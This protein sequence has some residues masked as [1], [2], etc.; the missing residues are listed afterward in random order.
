MYARGI[1]P[2]DII[3]ERYLVERLIARGGMGYVVAATHIGFGDRVAIKILF[4]EAAAQQE[5][6]QRFLREGRVARKITSPHVV[7]VTD[8]GTLHSGTPYMIMEYLDGTDLSRVLQRRGPLPVEQAT[9]FVL[10]VCEALAEAHVLGIVHRDLK[11]A[12]LFLTTGADGSPIVKVLDF[13]IAK[14]T[15]GIDVVSLTNTHSVMG[16][17]PYMPPEQLE[18][19]RTVDPR[20]DIWS[21]GVVLFELVSGR[22]P[23]EGPSLP[24]VFAR[25]LQGQP[26]RLDEVMPNAPDG[27][28][29]TIAQCLKRDRDER[30]SSVAEFARAL[31]PF[32]SPAG[33]ASIATIQSVWRRRD[34]AIVFSSRDPSATCSATTVMAKRPSEQPAAPPPGGNGQ[35]TLAN[36]VP[37]ATSPHM[38][39]LVLGH[40]DDPDSEEAIREVLV[41]CAWSLGGRTPSAAMLFAGIDHDHRI[42]LARI[43]EQWPDLPLIG[44]TTDGEVSSLRQFKEDSVAL[45]LFL[46]E[47]LSFGVGLGT[48]VASDPEKAARDAVEQA[49]GSMKQEPSLCL[50]TPASLIVSGVQVLEAIKGELGSTFPVFGGTAGDQL[51]LEHTYQF[52]GSKAVKD[53]LP[54]LLIG[55]PLQFAAGISS[56]WRPI[57]SK[58]VVT[59]A[60][61]NVLF[62]IDGRRA[63]DYYV[64]Q[65]GGF[66]T[67]A[68][69]RAMVVSYPLAV[70]TEDGYYLRSTFSVDPEAGVVH[71]LGDVPEGVTIQLANGSRDD[72]LA[73]SSSSI[74]QALK[75]FRGTAPAG[76]LV[77]SCAARRMLLGD[78]VVEEIERIRE[79]V[80]PGV[81]VVGFYTYGE[82]GPLR[83]GGDPKFHNM[84]CFSLVIGE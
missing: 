7:Q 53:G 19:A 62:E 32:A 51:R 55:G 11:P 13:G 12:N 49:R 44:C 41:E 28:A 47:R 59:K 83:E 78:R 6:V 75:A 24:H 80:P 4:P 81:P 67:P 74:S 68:E 37:T 3:A 16:S 48:G 65:I 5:F 58:G 22:Q 42:L 15:G 79:A 54:V 50:T 9:D 30:Y 66:S 77:F 1:E 43:A 23:F 64:D 39:E 63:A 46:S 40:S 82:M 21:L 17:G 31:D 35:G 71:C 84:T 73:G 76:V 72:V 2:G 25:I 14:S 56:G 70:L 60:K 27:F 26:T 29:D 8:V 34:H 18:S 33:R 20:S 10:Q 61:G 45:V 36:V 69:L 57:G 52:C 38:L